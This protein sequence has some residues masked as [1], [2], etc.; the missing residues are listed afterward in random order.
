MYCFA[1]SNQE[2]V[3]SVNAEA[4]ARCDTSRE[5]AK[6]RG[7]SGRRIL[8]SLKGAI[9]T[10]K[11]FENTQEDMNSFPER[12]SIMKRLLDAPKQ[13][14]REYKEK[15]KMVSIF[16]EINDF[17]VVEVVVVLRGIF[18]AKCSISV[19]LRNVRK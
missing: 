11:S 17:V 10:T 15:A 4:D 12:Q 7:I 9:I 1:G 5:M 19:G 6:S 13:A 2:R 8:D 3:E 18:V 14:K 16:E